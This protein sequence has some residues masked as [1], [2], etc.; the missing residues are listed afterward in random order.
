MN[1]RIPFPHIITNKFY[2]HLG[3]K[4]FN[5]I[6]QTECNFTIKTN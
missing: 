2:M 5:A 1:L 6:M 3:K 4:L